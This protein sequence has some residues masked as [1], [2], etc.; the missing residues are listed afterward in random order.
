MLG[1]VNGSCCRAAHGT[2]GLGML[3]FAYQMQSDAMVPVRAWA[4]MAASSGGS[5]LL[6]HHSA[7]RNLSAVYELI[8]RAGLSHTRPPFGIRS[9]TVGN[10]EVEVREEAAARTPFATLLHFKKDIATAQPRVLL[11]APLSGHFSTLLRA[12]VRTMLPDHDVFITDW[13]NARDIPIMAGRF[14]VD[15]YAN[16]LIKFLETIGPGAHV[17]AVCQPCVSVLAAV[18]MMAQAGNPAQPRSMTLMAGPI[19]TRINPTKVN[20]LA[21]K[22]SIE[23]FERALTAAVPPR[24]PG[25]YRRVYPGFV[26]LVAFMS[27]NLERHLKA[28]RELYEHLA[29]GDLGKA[30]VTKAFYDEYFAV[31]DLTAEF[32]LETVRL[33]FQEHAL[34]LGKLEWHG[35]RVDPTAIRK[36]MLFTVEGERD[37][38]CAVGQT[39]AAHDLCSKLRPYL[40]R[41]HLQA[42]VG[43]YGVFSGKRWENQIYPILK[44]I[45]L[46][47]D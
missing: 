27:M 5:P 45:I 21:K 12:T 6:A 14:G 34:P 31:L 25:A 41:H 1:I 4:G 16:H 10:R 9:I 47:S 24:Y 46:S 32:Y 11:V 13:H 39:V 23:W 44:N 15:E 33:I 38:I 28:H 42:G 36:T 35:H 22:R 29:N 3:Y 40:K 17:L 43:H 37:D 20:A 19:D 2:R 7:L 18:A 8:A 26:Q 30:A